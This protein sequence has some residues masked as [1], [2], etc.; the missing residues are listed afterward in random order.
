MLEARHGRGVLRH[1]VHGTQDI[2]LAESRGHRMTKNNV[3]TN[4]VV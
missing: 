3:V 4:S 1:R 2:R